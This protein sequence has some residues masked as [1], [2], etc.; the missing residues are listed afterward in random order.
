MRYLLFFIIL[1]QRYLC[2]PADTLL[3]G[4]LLLTN[5]TEK[6]NRLYQRG[7]AMRNNDV[8]RSWKYAA[9]SEKFAAG[10]G[11]PRHLAKSYNLLGILHYKKGD[12]G[13][14]LQYHERALAIRTE[15]K[16]QLGIALSLTNIGN[17]D[18][19]LRLF[20][21]AERA[22]LQ[23]LA[24]YKE[25]GDE[26]RLANCM[27]NLG[28]LKQNQDMQEEACEYYQA[29]L[30]AAVRLNDYGMRAICL[31][32]LALVYAARG[33]DDKAEGMNE[34]ALKLRRLMENEVESADS[35]LNLAALYL[36][37]KKNNKAKKCLDT[38]YYIATANNYFEARQEAY[39][40]YAEYYSAQN[41]PAE[42]YKWLS[43][44]C[45]GRDSIV[46]ESG[47]QQTL[48]TDYSETES[49]TAAIKPVL[50]NLW[51]LTTLFIF[52]IFVPLILM[53]F[54]R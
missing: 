17:I 48:I 42:A 38:A 36:R 33:E 52:L 28:A 12:Y 20:E 27:I 9:L 23:A 43:R 47:M 15:I 25:T 49:G 35:Y 39:R 22:Y 18:V 44:Y 8:R 53:Y 45:A 19:D 10:S 11:S 29:A 14:A 40:Y 31:N 50:N 51:L 2:Q 3:P 21:K 13:R 1:S 32:N 41:Q 7:F 54:K 30:S 6:V 24:I 34:D 5:D 16:D 37:S 26:A 46:R 4:I